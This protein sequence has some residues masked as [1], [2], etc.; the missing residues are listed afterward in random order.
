MSASGGA[1]QSNSHYEEDQR[2]L[3]PS[4]AIYWEKPRM[5]R[6]SVDYTMI[7]GNYIY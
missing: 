4:S 5:E 2:L 7:M 1:I 3:W 6:P